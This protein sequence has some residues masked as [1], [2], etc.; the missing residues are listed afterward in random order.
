MNHVR[1]GFLLAGAL[2]L[3]CACS[4]TKHIPEGEKLYTG[5]EKTEVTGD[6]K[7]LSA[8]GKSA[9]SDA[10]SALSFPPNNS[11]FGSSSVRIPF[12]MGLWI[13]NGFYN[14][15]K[16]FGKWI[17]NKLGSTP[18][19]IS[20]AAPETR[21]QIARNILRDNGFFNAKVDYDVIDKRNRKAKIRYTITPGPV[22][23][24][25]SIAYLFPV[26]RLDSLV[27][28]TYD[29]RLLLKGADF[30]VDRL[31]AERTR[32]NSLFRN[33]GY[34]YS[35]PDFVKFAADTLLA[36]NKVALRVAQQANL[37]QFV[38][39]QWYIGDIDVHLNGYNGEPGKDTMTYKGVTIH[40]T[41]PLRIRPS[42][43]Y[44][45]LKF[46]E[47][48]LFSA[49][50]H[51]RSQENLYRM[52]IFR[53]AELTYAPQDTL[54]QGNKLN[55]NVGATFD[56]PY[57]GNIEFNVT[58]KS[59]DQLGPGVIFGITRRNAFRGGENLSLRLRGSY[60][61]QVNNRNDGNKN[62]INS[63]EV[64][65]VL[66]VT[67]PRFM[68]PGMHKR[69][70]RYPVTTDMRLYVT[71]M[72]RA[73]F[74][75]LLTFGGSDTYS[76]QTSPVSRHSFTLFK[77]SFN[78]LQHTTAEFDS[79]SAA[80]PALYL[81]LQ[82]QF[83]PSMSYTYTYDDISKGKRGNIWWESSVTSAGN[84]TSLLFAAFGQKLKEEGK[85][86]MGNPFSQFAK[87]T[88]EIRYTYKIDRNQT[89]ATRFMAGVLLAYGNAKVA[90]YNE[91]FYIGGANS[92]RA[93]TIRSIGP[94]SYRPPEK[95]KYS[96]IDQTGNFKLEANV[97]YRFRIAGNLFGA[98]F[99][100]AGN[101]WLL[102]PDPARPG[103]QLDTKDFWR[104]IALGTGVGIRYDLT[105]IVLRLDMGIAL[106]DPYQ[107]DKKGYYN[108]PKFKNGIGLHFAIG[109]PF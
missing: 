57:D 46:H 28:A 99:L 19:L 67:F 84:I 25:D 3:L 29:E 55:T 32:L 69:E 76:L 98:T 26:P 91:Q 96:Y 27:R 82:N 106:H 108:I 100:D 88:S 72:N 60:E 101:I 52:G 83:V 62:L 8:S 30:S 97:E 104:E 65:A 5:L 14:K 36:P 79:I 48:E 51:L 20:T 4:T 10:E 78:L 11:L 38:K 1:K 41:K 45:S 33:N 81:S 54:L 9:L 94:G 31:L 34:Y 92:I 6:T 107:T 24:L 109:Y 58:S 75:K 50:D 35:R 43:L 73:R 87:F 21:S 49:A 40:Y 68:F 71:L 22:S 86:L 59:N 61:W 53:L 95:D 89:L 80:N 63:Y 56:L 47:G 66:G 2:L 42:L 77:L 93:F 102:K 23:T 90:P 85:N 16:R 15:E 17:F 70:T 64:G 74:F 103:G 18:K 37:P 7:S 12:P 39:E 44:R 105:F 13:Y